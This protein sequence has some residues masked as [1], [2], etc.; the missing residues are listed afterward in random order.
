MN[1]II[2]PGKHIHIL[3]NEHD[4]KR[5]KYFTDYNWYVI[6]F[7]ER[8]I[9]KNPESCC[10]EIANFIF[11]LTGDEKYFSKLESTSLV[12]RVKMWTYKE[13]EEFI[14]QNQRKSYCDFD[15]T[16]PN[17]D[18]KL[19]FRPLKHDNKNYIFNTNFEFVET[20]LHN[21]IT[22]K[23]KFSLYKAKFKRYMI[24]IDWKDGAANYYLNQLDINHLIFTEVKTGFQFIFERRF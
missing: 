17:L 23:G 20:D 2:G 6:R 15:K 13:A 12:S 16:Y 18:S 1:L 19:I 7:S 4:E 8:Q 22:D 24:V 21:N 5:N 10:L 11:D 3:N 14:K 9:I